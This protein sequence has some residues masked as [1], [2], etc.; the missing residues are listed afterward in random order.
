MCESVGDD[1]PGRNE[2]ELAG[3]IAP[4]ADYDLLRVV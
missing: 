3:I 4:V 1:A 2:S